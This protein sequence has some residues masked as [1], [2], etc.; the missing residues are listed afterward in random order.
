MQPLIALLQVGEQHWFHSLA[1]AF[2]F[3]DMG[4][5]A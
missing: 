1:G 5:P 3:D 2:A 4:E